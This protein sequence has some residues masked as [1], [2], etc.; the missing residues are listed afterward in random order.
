MAVCM[1]LMDVR[2][3]NQVQPPPPPPSYCNHR[4]ALQKAIFS[5]V[6]MIL[7]PTPDPKKVTS[8]G[9]MGKITLN[10]ALKMRIGTRP[11]NTHL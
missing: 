3:Y 7:L 6:L 2:D 10:M 5:P 9:L 1:C 8:W 11:M 4:I